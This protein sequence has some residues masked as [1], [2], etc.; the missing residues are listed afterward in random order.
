MVPRSTLMRVPCDIPL[1]GD[2]EAVLKDALE[3]YEELVTQWV[4]TAPHAGLIRP[5]QTVT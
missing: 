4:D 2:E 1:T 5:S 3:V